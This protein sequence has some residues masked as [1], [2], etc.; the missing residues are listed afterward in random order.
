MN[1]RKPLSL[2]ETATSL[3]CGQGSECPHHYS[4]ITKCAFRGA[5]KSW[6]GLRRS[7]AC[8]TS[9]GFKAVKQR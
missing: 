8:G 7:E 3:S 1:C 6:T 9:G 4:N 2:W 5:D